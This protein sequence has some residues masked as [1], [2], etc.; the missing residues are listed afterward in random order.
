MAEARPMGVPG[1]ALGGGLLGTAANDTAGMRAGPID[2]CNNC[3]V[4]F[5]G[6]GWNL[7]ETW[8]KNGDLHKTYL[9]IV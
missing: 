2:S 4:V 7:C 8:C 9:H 3:A 6:T 5:K 1:G